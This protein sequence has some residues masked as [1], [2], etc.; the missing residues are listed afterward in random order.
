MYE[1][2]LALSIFYL[3]N[4]ITYEGFESISEFEIVLHSAVFFQ[5]E[6]ELG[7]DFIF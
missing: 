1:Y 5:L 3:I 2:S 4:E 7:I 6:K